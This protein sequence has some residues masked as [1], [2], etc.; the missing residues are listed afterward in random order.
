MTRSATGRRGEALAERYLTRQ[1]AVTLERNY[2]CKAGE[3][4]LV[5]KDGGEIAF[6][7]VRT[8][9]SL[10]YGSPEESITPGKQRKMAE[11][12]LAFLQEHPDLCECGWRIDLI[13][14]QLEAGKVTAVEHYRHVLS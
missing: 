7:E 6:V 4:D 3:I 2:R 1:G 5:V 8:R 13:A 10:E 9:S 14:I 11:C 12:A